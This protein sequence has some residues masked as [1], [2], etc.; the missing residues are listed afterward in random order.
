[1][2][3]S[4][5][6]VVRV[7]T[8]IKG[9]VAKYLGVIL[10][11][12]LS[13]EENIEERRKTSFIAWFACI[14]CIGKSLGFSPMIIRWLYLSIKRPILTY[15]YLVWCMPYVKRFVVLDWREIKGSMCWHDELSKVNSYHLSPMDL[16]VE[17]IV[18]KSALR[19]QRVGLFKERSYGHK[20][21]LPK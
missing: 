16:V 7:W 2:L 14:N 19:L 12:W 17:S 5:L 8:K 1:M 3:Q 10:D 6:R 20:A 13:W 21:I 15:A 9:L 4:A 11:R 18:T